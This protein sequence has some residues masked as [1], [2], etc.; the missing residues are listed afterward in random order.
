MP[1]VTGAMIL[2]IIGILGSVKLKV[3]GIVSE[4]SLVI[5]IGFSLLV[6]IF[7]AYSNRIK[8]LNFR[9]LKLT[10]EEI[11]ETE[12]AVRELAAAVFMVFTTR[13]PALQLSGMD[14]DKEKHQKALVKLAAL[15]SNKKR[16]NK[17][18]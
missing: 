4:P 1:R 2:S 11:K 5:L 3:D 9:E 6:G 10:L 17:A 12:D 15:A 8:E 16:E 13:P 7:I 14:W 18:E